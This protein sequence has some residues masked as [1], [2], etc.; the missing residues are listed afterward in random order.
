MLLLKYYTFKTNIDKFFYTDLQIYSND[1]SVY[2]IFIFYVVV[3]YGFSAKLVDLFES[4]SVTY[5]FH[6]LIS[7]N[8]EIK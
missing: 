6:L 3:F 5:V 7:A 8:F 1:C 4:I 2:G